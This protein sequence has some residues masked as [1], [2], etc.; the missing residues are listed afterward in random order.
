MRD[1]FIIHYL[2]EST[3]C[4]L[5]IL[6]KHI[7]AFGSLVRV[8]ISSIFSPVNKKEGREGKEKKTSSSYAASKLDDM[9]FAIFPTPE[10]S[11]GLMYIRTWSL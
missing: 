9:E 6:H 5:L 7:M 1:T 2:N 8:H 10:K 4:V 3:H 11:M